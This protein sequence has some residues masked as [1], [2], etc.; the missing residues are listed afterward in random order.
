[1]SSTPVWYDKPNPQRT[2]RPEAPEIDAK[3]GKI[4]K[5]R[6]GATKNEAAS[7]GRSL[8]FLQGCDRYREY[9]RRVVRLKGLE[10]TDTSRKLGIC[11]EAFTLTYRGGSFPAI[12][13]A[14]PSHS[15]VDLNSSRI[16]SSSRMP[17]RSRAR[18]GRVLD[19]RRPSSS[20]L[21]NRSWDH[22]GH[23]KG[24]GVGPRFTLPPG[25]A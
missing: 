8:C 12:A 23:L 6:A 13:A 15:S 1:M 4:A 9:C 18:F 2:P 20:F 24:R 10:G 25:I 7:D 21:T 5:P 3:L 16:V 19:I 22:R 14:I 11:I 17:R